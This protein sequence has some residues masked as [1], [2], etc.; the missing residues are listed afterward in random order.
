MN[1]SPTHEHH[2]YVINFGQM[3]EDD[4]RKWPDLMEIVERRVKPDRN[5]D[6]RDVRRRYWWRFA[7]SAPA[8][9]ATI[10]GLPRVLAIARVSQSAAFAFLPASIV[11]SEQLVVFA[12]S[13]HAAFTT[14]QARPHEV[15]A[16]FFASSMK[17][18]LRYTPSDCFE[19]F[20]FPDGW[21]TN[22]ALEATGKAYY[23]FRAA[24]MVKNDEGLTKTYNRFHDPDERSPDI[25]KLR[26]LHADMDRAVLDAYGWRD[27]PTACQFLLDHDDGPD[28]DEE[29]GKKRKRKPYRHRWPDDVRDEVLARLIELNRARAE[30]EKKRGLAVTRKAR[31]EGE[32]EDEGEG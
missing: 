20:P 21:Q 32:E 6:K 3:A 17:D 5:K 1:T 25:L 4:A 8:L 16:R 18:D 31:P 11:L 12:L 13:A 28:D 15:W 23:D 10:R 24:L 30:D 29:A 26:A 7:E 14:L 27:I 22:P 19:T 2:R 9:Y